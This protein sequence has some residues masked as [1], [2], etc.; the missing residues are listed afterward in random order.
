METKIPHP[1]QKYSLMKVCP[2][3]CDAHPIKR[4]GKRWSEEGCFNPGKRPVPE[5]PEEEPHEAK[6][7]EEVNEWLQNGGTAG[8]IARG[9]LVFIDIDDPE[10][11]DVLNSQLPSTFTVRSGNGHHYYYRCHDWNENITFKDF[12]GEIASFRADEQYVII[13]PSVNYSPASRKAEGYMASEI[14]EGN[15][16]ESTVAV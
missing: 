6:P 15:S 14:A 10:V 4:E 5:G 11:D 1:L 16:V 13:P 7:L 2:P 3:D 8:I 12:D 9:R